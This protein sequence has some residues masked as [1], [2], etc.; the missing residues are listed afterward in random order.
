MIHILFSSSAAGTLRQLL[1]SRN[2][3]QRVVDLSDCLDWGPIAHDNCRDREAWFN[4]HAPTSFCE[5]DW[6]C[7]SLKRFNDGVAN[8]REWLIW[9]APLSAAEQAGLYW[10]LHHFDAGRAQMIIAD[11]PL[12]KAGRDEAPFS[13]GELDQDLQ[14]E[15]LDECPRV[16]WDQSRF[17]KEVWSSLIND[18]ALLRVVIDGELRSTSDDYFDA[19]LV[20]SC[21]LEWTKWLR[22]IGDAMGALWDLGHSVHD[23][24]LIWR[25]RHLIHEGVIHSDGPAPRFGDEPNQLRIRR[26]R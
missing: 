20:R 11:Y 25:L 22:V 4:R 18:D 26:V 23:D 8:D 12:S 3:K 14:L 19:N 5:M 10:F 24:F 1:Y 2:S 16:P 6:L 15:L 21:P 17:P 7:E 9:I 13:L